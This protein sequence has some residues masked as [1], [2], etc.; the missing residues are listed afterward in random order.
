[1]TG[2]DHR[3]K[4]VDMDKPAPPA[5]ILTMGALARGSS[6]QSAPTDNQARRTSTAVITCRRCGAKA[7]VCAT[8]QPIAISAF[9]EHFCKCPVVAS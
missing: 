9:A 6:R 4:I 3:S 8:S 5:I 7:H 1:M 2:P